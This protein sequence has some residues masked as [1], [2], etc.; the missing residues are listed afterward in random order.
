MAPLSGDFTER[1]FVEVR[2]SLCHIEQK[3]HTIKVAT[4]VSGL[5][6]EIMLL[7]LSS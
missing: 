2:R 4:N 3:K 5:G 1:D 7:W 6:L